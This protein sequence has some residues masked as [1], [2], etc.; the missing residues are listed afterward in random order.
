MWCAG[1]AP[2]P[3]RSEDELNIKAATF[4]A[5]EEPP[6]QKDDM[7]YGAHNSVRGSKRIY[8]VHNL[9]GI[10]GGDSKIERE[11]MTDSLEGLELGTV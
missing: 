11:A 4:S 5:R 10:F 2:G 3:C 8:Q 1:E 7:E 6:R 9:I